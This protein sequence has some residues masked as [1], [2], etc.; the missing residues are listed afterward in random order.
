MTT[1]RA[2]KLREINARM[3]LLENRLER[4][5][6]RT[7]RMYGKSDAVKRF[8]AAQQLRERYARELRMLEHSIRSIV[9][10]MIEEGEI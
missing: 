6:I 8:V 4:L 9:K 1:P 2:L 10:N 3:G 7:A 5:E